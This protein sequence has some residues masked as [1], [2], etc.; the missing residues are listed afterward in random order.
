MGLK[1][2]H[3][4]LQSNQVHLLTEADNNK[5]LS[6]GMRALTITFSKG[7]KKEGVQLERYHLPVLKTL[8]KKTS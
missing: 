6:R 4:S 5:I 8:P 1:V 3:F 2:I 7:L